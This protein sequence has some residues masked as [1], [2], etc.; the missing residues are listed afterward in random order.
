LPLDALE[1]AQI[2]VS[3]NRVNAC[4]VCGA[5]EWLEVL[6]IDAAPATCASVFDSA[7]QARGVPHG[8][9]DLM[10]CE[11]CGFL[12]NACFERELADIGARYESSQSAS[13][14]F[15][16][17]ANSLAESWVTRHQLRGKTV[18]E[19]G[20]GHGDFLVAMLAAGV[21]HAIGFDPLGD[22]ARVADSSGGRMQVLPKRFE[23]HMP[24]PEGA[25]LICRHTLEHEPD[26]AGLLGAVRRWCAANPTRVV[27]FEVPASERILDERAFW[28]VYYEHCNY[29][30]AD[31]LRL[32][33]ERAGFE[34]QRLD[35]LYGGQ[36]LI[37]EAT[38]GT[39][40]VRPSSGGAA[41]AVAAA[42]AFGADVRRM[43][44]RCDQRLRRLAAESG[45]VVLWQ[46]AAKTVGFIT[47]LPSTDVIGYAV[48][49]SPAR[50]DRYLPG[51]GLHVRAPESLRETQPATVVLMNP[52][53]VREVRAR[54]DELTP[55]TRLL[56]VNDLFA[57]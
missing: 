32:A 42:Q 29:F 4:A 30:S 13:A 8:T 3:G 41:T 43:I 27:L 51:S 14:H 31:T 6:H 50:H 23:A 17:F 38:S 40:A 15:G 22:P 7:A 34:V 1:A 18:V 20:C 52:V 37:A 33:F 12:F 48:D 45:P 28:D 9:I 36:Y 44:E 54:L 10:V 5:T 53:Y 47:M 11:Q 24:A 19:L 35:R 21:G 26:I 16:A 56:T 57:D 2:E 46:G 39:G 25:A 49:A 55:A